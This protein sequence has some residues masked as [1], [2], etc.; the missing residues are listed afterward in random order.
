MRCEDKLY[1]YL[2]KLSTTSFLQVRLAQEHGA[3]AVLLFPF[4]EDVSE[5]N[6]TGYP[7]SWGMKGD[8]MPRGSINLCKGDPLTPE[9]PSTGIYRP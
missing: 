2:L 5:R 9:W 6:E 3:S 8:A 4:P 1:T 7:D